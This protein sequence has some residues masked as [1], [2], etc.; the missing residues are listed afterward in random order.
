MIN[1]F[2]TNSQGNSTRKKLSF[3]QMVLEQYGYPYKKI[4]NFE[5]WTW[6]KWTHIR[7]KPIKTLKETFFCVWNDLSR[8]MDI[9]T[10]NIRIRQELQIIEMAKVIKYDW[11]K[12]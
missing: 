11:G 6:I 1:C 4:R 8:I 2:L 9:N 12:T 5:K 10:T 3:Q 7:F